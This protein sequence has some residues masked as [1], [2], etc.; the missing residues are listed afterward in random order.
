MLGNGCVGHYNL[1]V[2]QGMGCKGGCECVGRRCGEMER[3][4]GVDRVVGGQH[5]N[6]GV[7]RLDEL[8]TAAFR[9]YY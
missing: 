6:M 4:V 1:R 2:Y 8:S 7:C 9:R 3:L 5:G